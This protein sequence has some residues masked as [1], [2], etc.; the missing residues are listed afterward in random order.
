[1]KYLDLTY[2]DPARNLACDEALLDACEEGACGEI[3][4]VWEPLQLFVVL[5]YSNKIKTEINPFSSPAAALPVLRRPSGGG[6]VLQGPGCLNY[7]LILRIPEEGPL[8]GI[9]GTNCQVMEKN[10]RAAE[11]ASGAA[12]TIRGISDLTLG[13]L[14][15]SGNAQRRKRHALL[16]HGTFLYGFDL[17]LV[18]KYLAMPERQPDYRKN[19]PHGKF[20]TNLPA[21]PAGLKDA[22]RKAWGADQLLQTIPTAEITRLASEKYTS[23]TWT[24][25]F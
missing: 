25:K 19:R 7:S 11:E 10:R 24:N 16:F 22:L 14:K 9:N 20:I 17:S 15:F 13:E 3:L 6:T 8:A 23:P 1:M 4:R 2:P 18:E 21:S 12:V 5:G